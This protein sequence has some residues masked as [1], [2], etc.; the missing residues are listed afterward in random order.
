MKIEKL[1][2]NR[3]FV[4]VVL[5]CLGFIIYSNTFQS[6]FHFDDD[7]IVKNLNI[8][9]L[10][11]LGAVWKLWPTRFITF[12]TFIINYNFSQFHVFG[13][14]LVNLIVH[15]GCAILVWW[16]VIL[17][18]STPVIRK[19]KISQYSGLIA[20]FGA[21]IF[22]SH[23]IQ[24]ESVTY[25]Y[26]RTTSLAGF[27]Y[28]FSLCLYVKSRLLQ[29][30][31]SIASNWRILYVFSWVMC[32]ICMF[33]KENALTLPL[34]IILYEFCFFRKGRNIKWKHT[35]PFLIILPIIPIFLFSTKPAT[36]TDIQ[37]LIEYPTTAY[38]YFLTQL[39]VMITYI[40]LLFLPLNQNL[41]YCYPISKSL[42]ELPTALSLFLLSFI[43]LTAIRIFSRYRLISFSIFWFFLTLL[44][45][46][47]I[48]PMKDAI[49]EHRLYLPMVGYS[50][51]L[52]GLI[53][54]RFGDKT[55]RLMVTVLIAL[56][57]C[58]SMLTYAR[59]SVW[60]N[61]F[62]L[63]DDIIRKSPLKA[64]PYCNRGNAYSD[65]GDYDRAI[66]DYTQAIKIDPNCALAYYNRGNSYKDKGDF[67]QA[68][69]DY[70]KAIEI[71]PDYAIAYHNRAVVYFYKQEYDKSWYNVYK[72]EAFGYKFHP[73]FLEGLR[74]ESGRKR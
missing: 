11:D 18:L 27:F 39:R 42:F 44:P 2:Y 9:N 54:Y 60:K 19:D 62:T 25:I 49:F 52:A 73:G 57:T 36:F 12:L 4:V 47:S 26:Q 13:Y 14:H 32:V 20:L 72:A 45:E 66:S 10:T 6:A 71:K 70:N 33:T 58:Y 5:C 41:D 40:R 23:P 28:I 7:F 65:R 50:L 69:R 35:A 16:F 8:R 21:L 53:Y 61:E 30:G 48:I 31:N 15:L 74:E 24:T 64:R 22:L 37:R 29:T 17:T 1:S 46:S 34:M 67:D 38:Y 56:I 55:L 63:S 68:V 3:V 59:N 43:M 51:F